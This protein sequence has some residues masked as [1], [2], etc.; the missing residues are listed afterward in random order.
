[1]N[2]KRGRMNRRQVVAG[3]A[4]GAAGLILASKGVG[5]SSSRYGVPGVMRGQGSA[6]IPTPRNETLIV[7]QSTNNVWDSFNPFI[8]NGEAYNYGL[9]QVCR[10]NMFVVNFLTGETTPWLATKYEYN[11]DFTECTLHLNPNVTWSDGKPYTSADVEFTENMLLQNSNLNGSAG[12][13]ENA[14]AVKATDPQTVVYTLTKP[15]PRFHYRFHAGII[16]DAMRVVPK[17]I[18]EDKDPGTF[19]FNPPVYTGPYTLQESSSSKLYYLWKKSD[20]YWNKATLDPKPGYVMYVQ[21]T[22]P[23]TAVQ[24]FMAGNVDVTSA[25]YLNQQVIASQYDKTSSYIF[26]DPC[27]RGFYFNAESPSGLFS[28]PEGRWAMS[29]LIDRETIAQTVWQPPSHPATYPWADY[30]GWQKWAP[31][32]VMSKYDLTY[33]IDKANELLDKI[34]A[35]RDGD[36]RSLNGKP[37]N[38][39]MITPVPTNGAEYQIGQTFT[40]AAKEVGIIVDLKSLPGSAFGDAYDVGDFDM[41]CHWICGMQF[42]PDQLFTGFHS[43]NYTPLGQRANK[44]GDQGKERFKSAEFDKIID[45]MDVVNPD[46]EKNF[47][48]FTEGLD[49][50]LKELPAVPSIQTL[51]PFMYNTTYWTNWPDDKNPTTIPANW[52]G[53]FLFTIGNLQAAEG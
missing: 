35:T 20:N 34:G 11:E 31:D 26:P 33:S 1:M 43:R 7:E 50:F 36:V 2:V 28:T 39:T 42:D 22:S 27:P 47:H 21:Q 9:S 12:L 45:Q 14:K 30:P 4:G 24:E 23:D 16:A 37:L 44:G 17:H 25:D 3:A 18:W 41:T 40:A 32:S 48:L 38:L 8:P 15:N 19:T 49:V 10:E 6:N 51:Y 13:A 46:E 29:H 5:A 53:Q 52:W